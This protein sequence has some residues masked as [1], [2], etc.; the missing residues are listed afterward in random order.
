M[1]EKEEII[2]GLED[3]IEDRKSFLDAGEINDKENPFVK[4]IKTLKGAIELIKKQDN[5]SLEME[6]ENYRRAFEKKDEEVKKIE[7][8]NKKYKHAL[9]N[10]CLKM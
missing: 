5:R 2:K 10:V 8:E 9:L 7:E 6:K 4:D 3:L 1:R